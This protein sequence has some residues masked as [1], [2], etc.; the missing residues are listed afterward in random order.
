MLFR[1]ACYNIGMSMCLYVER[2]SSAVECPTRNQVSPD[3][4]PPF[5]RFRRLGVFVLSIDGLKTI[6]NMLTFGCF[7]YIFVYIQMSV[8]SGCLELS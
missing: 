1:G 8:N 5:L 3:S 6:L 2:G 4:N 7:I